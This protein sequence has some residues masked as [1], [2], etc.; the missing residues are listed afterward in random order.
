VP[1]LRYWR[2]LQGVLAVRLKIFVVRLQEVRT[3]FRFPRWLTLNAYGSG[4]R[5]ILYGIPYADWNATLSDRA[6]WSKLPG[7]ARVL[8]V[9]ATPF[10]S[11]A[12]SDDV[13]IAMKTSHMVRR[14]GGRALQPTSQA[15][16][17]LEDKAKFA[18][19]MA[20]NGFGDYCPRTYAGRQE[21]VFPCMLKRTDL[22][23][24]LGVAI[25]RSAEHLDE[26]LQTRM[27]RGHPHL[28]QAIVPG[29]IEYA[30]YCV[31]RGGRVLWS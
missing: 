15:I 22:S 13:V 12:R 19:Y 26:L 7:V 5:V 8:R 11:G 23:A 31:S 20:A 27:F 6:L 18:A 9:P 24:S 17:V 2:F 28:L 30:T 29:N 4:R 25:A 3:F 21:A 10:G 16:A 1:L 14:P